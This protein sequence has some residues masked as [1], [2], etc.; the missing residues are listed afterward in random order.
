[1][2]PLLDGQAGTT[3]GAVA[4]LKDAEFVELDAIELLMRTEEDVKE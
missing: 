2:V 1:M 3:D 4:E